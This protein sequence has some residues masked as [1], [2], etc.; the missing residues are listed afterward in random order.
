MPNATLELQIATFLDIAIDRITTQQD[1]I[2]IHCA[3]DS[4]MIHI[5]NEW[6]RLT[7]N[8]GDR[9]KYLVLHK[10]DYQLPLPLNRGMWE[11]MSYS[12]VSNPR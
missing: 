2:L 5:Q 9:A 10:D 12:L 6:C 7:L 1:R 4:E 3:S 8:F 11:A